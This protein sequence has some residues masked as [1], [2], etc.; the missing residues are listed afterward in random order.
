M[1]TKNYTVEGMTC[2]HCV[3]SVTEEVSEVPGVSGVDVDLA[4]G[5]LTVTAEQVDDAAVA[6]AVEEAGY[7]LAAPADRG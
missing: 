3:M 2:Q 5:L 7:A 1:A 4:S 6:A